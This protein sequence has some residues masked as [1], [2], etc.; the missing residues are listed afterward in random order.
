MLKGGARSCLNSG[1]KAR[2]MDRYCPHCGK[3]FTGHMNKKFCGPKC[4][5]RYHNTH[6]PRGLDA[7]KE[8]ESWE[9]Y[10][11]TVHPFS[12]EAFEQ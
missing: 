5:D 1:T 4:K 8:S 6:N 9:S 10:A 7:R 12:S 3:P 11:E 2:T